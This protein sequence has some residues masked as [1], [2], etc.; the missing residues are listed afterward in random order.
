LSVWRKDFFDKIFE[1]GQ[2]KTGYKDFD[3]IIGLNASKNIERYVPKIFEN[4]RL[5]EEIQNDRYR[6]YNVSTN[7]N[8]ITIRRRSGLA[9]RTSEMIK[10]EYEK[11]CLFLDSLIDSEII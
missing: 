8:V 1:F 10:V 11:F 9:M 7:N 3:Q 4:S 5:R 2:T 6:T